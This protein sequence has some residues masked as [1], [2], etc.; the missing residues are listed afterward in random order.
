MVTFSLL[1]ILMCSMDQVLYMVKEVS[2]QVLPVDNDEPFP[3]H[4]VVV[5][6]EL[7]GF[8]V[9]LQL[10]VH[11]CT[12]TNVVAAWSRDALVHAN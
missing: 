8:A 12:Y 7:Q 9:L 5:L 10:F 3:L 11:L 6:K 1:L 2:C 4:W